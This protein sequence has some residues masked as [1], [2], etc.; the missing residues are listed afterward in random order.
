MKKFTVFFGVFLV[1]CVFFLSAQ[2]RNDPAISTILN[3]FAARNY[4][5]A[6]VT[7]AELDLIIQAGIRAPSARNGQPWHF[8]VVQNQALAKK[9]IP[10]VTDGS[11]LIVVSAAG[12]GKTNGAVILD[13]GLAVQSMYLAAQALGLGSRIYTGPID[14]INKDFKK[15]LGLP[16]NVSAIAVIRIGRLPANVDAVSSAS[17]RN[18]A[19]KIVTYK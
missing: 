15:D 9:I 11:I 8:T 17:P 12:D 6:T 13:C 7:K 19:D 4:S 5:S 2:N 10:Q 18:S 3:H 14:T 1:F 16:D